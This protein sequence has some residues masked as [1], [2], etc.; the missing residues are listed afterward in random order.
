MA[1]AQAAMVSNN[2]LISD[3]NH[4]MTV[5]QIL[6]DLDRQDVKDMLVSMGVSPDA[7]KT[8]VAQLTEAELAQLHNEIDQL[9]TG[10]GILGVI[11]VVFVV[12][13]ITDMLGATDVFGF[14]HNINHR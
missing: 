7:A 2:A 1:T 5:D 6:N 14:V 4:T 13:V 12:L 8:R 3:A 11:L 10:S 9:P